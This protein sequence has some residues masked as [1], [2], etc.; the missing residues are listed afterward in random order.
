MARKTKEYKYLLHLYSRVNKYLSDN[1]PKTEELEEVIVSFCTVVE[2]VLKMKLHS[3]NPILI[4]DV[5]K[6]KDDDAISALAMKTDTS[7]ETIKIQSTLNRFKILFKKTFSDEELISIKDIYNVRNNLVHSYLSEE[8]VTLDKDDF[9]KKMSFI[10][11]KISKLTKSL[12][13]K[14]RILSSTPKKSYTE[15]EFKKAI[16]DELMK[17]I[18]QPVKSNYS[19]LL[20]TSDNIANGY[21]SHNSY[22]KKCPR[23]QLFEFGVSNKKFG[24]S[25]YGI[26]GNISVIEAVLFNSVTSLGGDLG[27]YSHPQIYRCKKCNLELTQSEYELYL[28]EISKENNGSDPSKYPI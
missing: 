18:G 20:Y 24:A 21:S 13:G 28:K 14:E 11:P 25:G 3:K 22:D 2:R 5:S 8:R 16:I 17:K 27:R 9:I 6:L 12:L 19:E 7:V 23:C 26:G 1:K 10:W 4:F 15:A